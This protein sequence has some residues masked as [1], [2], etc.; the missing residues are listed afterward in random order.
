MIAANKTQRSL[1]SPEQSRSQML[2]ITLLLCL[3]YHS[4]PDGAAR[5]P[6]SH[7]LLLRES[8]HV[9]GVSGLFINICDL[10][11][12]TDGVC[13]RACVRARVRACAREHKQSRSWGTPKCVYLY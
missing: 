8:V 9:M 10:L 3:H 2:L 6:R 7:K 1:W 13:V 4:S 5:W 11:P 12:N